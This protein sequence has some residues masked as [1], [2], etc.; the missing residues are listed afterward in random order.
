MTALIE[1][2]RAAV[3]FDLATGTV[4]VRLAVD[5][6]GGRMAV[7]MPIASPMVKTIEPGEV[8]E[9][10]FAMPEHTFQA[11]VD[12]AWDAGIRPTQLK[13]EHAAGS[14]AMKAVQAHLAD[15][16]RLVFAT[17]ETGPDRPITVS[18]RESG[19]TVATF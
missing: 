14:E 1:A 5:L 10:A 17:Q 11:L 8:S 16:R 2:S 12:S 19:D 13:K 4:Q 3:N 7:V 15:M 9:P 6:H 18:L